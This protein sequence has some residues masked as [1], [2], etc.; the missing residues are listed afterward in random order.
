ME[1]WAGVV[2]LIYVHVSD[3]HFGQER[4][5]EVYVHDDVKRCLVADVADVMTA[6]GIDRMDGVLVTGDIAFSGKKSEFDLAAQWL[7]RLTDV[8]G[9][10]KTDVIVV[11]GNHDIDRDR[12]SAGAALMLSRIVEGGDDELDR[13]LDDAGDRE[14]LYAKFDD[15]RDFA[16]GYD[17]P[18]VSD[19]GVAVNRRVEIAPGRFLRFVG[20]NSALLCTGRGTE[21]GTLLIG[22]RQRVLPRTDGEELVVLCHHPLE[23]L[24]DQEVAS[25]YI[26]SRARVH[27]YGHLHRPSVEVE[28][29]VEEGDLLTVSAGAAV[30][31]NAGAYYQFTYNVLIFEW[32]ANSEALEVTIAPRS[33]NET[34]TM[35]NADTHQFEEAQFQRVLRCP[36]FKSQAIAAA[37]HAAAGD[38]QVEAGQAA[39]EETPSDAAGGTNMERSNDLLRLHFFRDLSAAQRLHALIEVG[40]LPKDWNIE[41]THTIER[42]LLDQ[43]LGSGLQD[44][45]ETAVGALRNALA[46]AE[47]GG[48][49]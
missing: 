18:L 40:V 34:K 8:I 46:T 41:L 31:P 24:Q 29:P 43:A 48:G 30:P 47:R 33:W 28:T 10:A 15:Y 4:G 25:Q 39:P 17:C 12:I 26:K 44:D 23:S 22:G 21:E 5:A 3:I 14:V 38:Y 19:G 36:N 2:P 9:C 27:I 6:S 45:L 49:E 35:F 13:F 20:L 32:D 1:H 11:P 37:L 42:R 7:D 16:E